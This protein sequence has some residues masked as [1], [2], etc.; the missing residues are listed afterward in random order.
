VKGWNKDLTGKWTL[1]TGRGVILISGKVDLR[2][3]LVRRGNKGHFTLMKRTIHQE[4]TI[5]LNI[6]AS[7][8][9][10]PNYIKKHYWA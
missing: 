7:D 2:L 10:A 9:G 4:E 6:Y 3:A 5:I 8:I 1:K